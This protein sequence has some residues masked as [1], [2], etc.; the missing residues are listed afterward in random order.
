MNK[1]TENILNRV[2]ETVPNYG[3]VN[4]MISTFND[5]EE[6]DRWDD[7]EDDDLEDDGGSHEDDD[8]YEAGYNDYDE[9]NER[10]CDC[11]DCFYCDG[12]N[13]AKSNDV[14]ND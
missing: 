12:Y 4:S 14:S 7:D 11:D 3:K 8:D 10:E 6:N 2:F 5:D 13:V 1:T 9:D